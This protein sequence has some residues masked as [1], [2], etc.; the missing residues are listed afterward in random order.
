MHCHLHLENTPGED[1]APKK[2]ANQ[3]ASKLTL[4]S[5]SLVFSSSHLNFQAAL[6]LSPTIAFLHSQHT[7]TQ[8]QAKHINFIQKTPHKLIYVF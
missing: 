6:P 2:P 7:P 1:Q 4:K 8:L 5:D 3:T